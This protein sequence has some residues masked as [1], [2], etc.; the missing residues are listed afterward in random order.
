MNTRKQI[1]LL[2]AALL[3]GIIIG[4]TV[5]YFLTAGD[6]AKKSGEVT[7]SIN[8]EKQLYS[9]GMHPDVISEEPGNCP[10]CGMKLTPIKGSGDIGSAEA[11][12]RKEK[13]FIGER[14]WIR[15]IFRISL[16]NRRWAW[17]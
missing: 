2:V 1:I 11:K 7:A 12:K 13:F 10:I 6:E 14:P 15:P 9:C 8:A 16:A 3:V 17:I 5:I 4:G